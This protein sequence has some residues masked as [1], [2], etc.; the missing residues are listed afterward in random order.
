M[1][2]SSGDYI[3]N[4]NIIQIRWFASIRDAP[5]KLFVPYTKGHTGLLILV[6]NV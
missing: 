2:N 6:Q 1:Y 4:G 3:N 5:A